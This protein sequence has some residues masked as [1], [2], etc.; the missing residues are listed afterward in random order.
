MGAI[1]GVRVTGKKRDMMRAMSLPVS[2]VWF[3]TFGLALLAGCSPALDWRELTVE[4]SGA[5]ALFPCRPENRVRQVKLVGA[6]VQMH[7]ASC[8]AGESN[9]A[10]SHL[11][12][13]DAVKAGQVLQQL[14]SLTA[15][16]MGGTPTVIGPCNVPGMTPNPLARR[17]AVKGK[18]DDG[19]TLEAEA[20]YFSRGSVVYQATLV[21]RHLDKQ[22][23]DTFFASI[24]TE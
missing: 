18:R 4:G 9:F 8:T 24:K 21:G 16:N 1:G 13:G 11:D 10:L 12:A 2:C 5:S 14:Q 20:I 22:V 15:A 17:L 7:L 19:A 23:V 3:T 6:S